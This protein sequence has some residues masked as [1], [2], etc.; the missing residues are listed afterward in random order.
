MKKIQKIIGKSIVIRKAQPSDLEAVFNNVWNDR[1][2]LSTTML[3]TSKT[4]NDAK[5]RLERTIKFQSDKDIFFIAL[6][7]TNEVIGLC[8]ML[9][10]K[11]N[12]FEETG[13][14]I[15]EKFQ[16]REYGTEMLNML[17]DVV[18]NYYGASHFIYTHC[19]G[20]FKSHA[21]CAKFGFQ[22]LNSKTRTRDWDEEDFIIHRYILKKED[23]QVIKFKYE[24]L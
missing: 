20:N 8:G 11:K 9:P 6:K 17:L 1:E 19:D 23:Y 10:N 22:Y 15:G 3:T 5:D 21:L 24:I 13:L 14:V 18:F 7:D 4:M 12:G 16:K 2:L